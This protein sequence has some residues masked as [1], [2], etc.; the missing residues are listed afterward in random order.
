YMCVEIMDD[1]FK[2]SDDYLNVDLVGNILTTVI[3]FMYNSKYGFVESNYA[4]SK[5]NFAA[6]NV[7]FTMGPASHAWN[8][9]SKEQELE[10]S[11][12][13]NPK[14]TETQERYCA[15]QSVGYLQVSIASHSKNADATSAFLQ[16]LTEA[17]YEL[18]RPAIIDTLMK[19]RYA[20]DPIDAKMWDYAI[21]ANVFDL[22]RVYG[23]LFTE[24][25]TEL[26]L[27]EKLIR[28]RIQAKSDNWGFVVDGYSEALAIMASNLAGAVAG[29]A[30]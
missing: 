4:K 24:E 18:T 5:E 30:D 19:G 27:P 29:L 7:L 11:V 10:Y 12:L 20:E 26:P 14:H 2:I 8:T 9:Y 22:G 16:A 23:Y 21:D 15:T 1:G 13:P 25:G 28:E 6:G 17:S 3:D